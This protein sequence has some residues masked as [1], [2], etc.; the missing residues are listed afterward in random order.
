M[1]NSL[2]FERRWRYRLAKHN[3]HL[4]IAQKG[5]SRYY[6]LTEGDEHAAPTEATKY[7]SESEMDSYVTKLR[8]MDADAGK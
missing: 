7:F 8:E 6:Y 4:H 2:S 5:G 1:E 3:L